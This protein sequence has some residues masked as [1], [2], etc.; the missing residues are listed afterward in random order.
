MQDH[1]QE[2]GRGLAF[3]VLWIMAVQLLDLLLAMAVWSAVAESYRM[4]WL[5]YLF[6]LLNL[7]L[8]W[9]GGYLMPKAFH[10]EKGR[11]TTTLLLIFITVNLL[12]SLL[13]PGF[14][15]KLGRVWT[16]P[17]QFTAIACF[18]F[19][20]WTGFSHSVFFFDVVEPILGLVALALMFFFLGIG[21]S[22]ARKREGKETNY[23]DVTP[24]VD[25]AGEGA[26]EDAEAE[27]PAESEEPAP[28]P[29]T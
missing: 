2:K 6:G 7:P 23:V 4:E 16:L 9:L 17:Q 1:T 11:R 14:F 29:T 21:L 22:G 8:Y 27:A 18:F 19:L 28:A 13:L 25:E 24:A 3:A 10:P 26:A 5:G 15:P 12:L 20:Y